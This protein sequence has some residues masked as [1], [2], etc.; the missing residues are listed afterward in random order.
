MRGESE[1]YGLPVQF[2]IER[3]ACFFFFCLF[4]FSSLVFV[5]VYTSSCIL[6]TKGATLL[7]LLCV[8]SIELR[9]Q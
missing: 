3:S 5:F 6:S 9:D 7:I 8:H 2:V 1:W 4:A